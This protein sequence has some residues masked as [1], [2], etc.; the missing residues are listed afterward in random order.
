MTKYVMLYKV[1]A[2]AGKRDELLECLLN[3]GARAR[4]LPGC[5]VFALNTD[6]ADGNVLWTY[7]LFRDEP[8]HQIYRDSL[9]DRDDFR[10][11]IEKS[12]PLVDRAPDA[13]RLD[14]IER[15]G[16]QLAVMC[17]PEGTGYAEIERLVARPGQRTALIEN[18]LQIAALAER[19]DGYRLVTVNGSVDDPN[20]VVLYK[21]FAS[22]GDNEAF[23]AAEE[24]AAL[25]GTAPSMTQGVA[26][27][28]SLDFKGS[29]VT[30]P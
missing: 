30:V 13:H 27:R 1:T 26:E 9:V 5:E 23:S 20:V 8:S 12:M 10:A 15:E 2:Y 21:V 28:I 17:T 4:T 24:V 29:G 11:H 22:Q 16:A 19:A 3:V 7:E 25:N 14:L 18:A 6:M